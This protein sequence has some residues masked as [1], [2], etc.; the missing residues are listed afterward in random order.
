MNDFPDFYS[1]DL[2]ELIISTLKYE[3]RDRPTFEQIA[4]N[5]I[6]QEFIPNNLS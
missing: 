4:E 3:P 5:P 2:K 6:I 1:V